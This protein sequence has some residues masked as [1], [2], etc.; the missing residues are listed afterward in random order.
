MVLVLVQIRNG[1]ITEE[2]LHI[3]SHV[4][5]QVNTLAIMIIQSLLYCQLRTRTLYSDNILLVLNGTVVNSVNT[6]LALNWHYDY[7]SLQ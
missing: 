2:R 1:I 3:L 7:N 5:G 4:P 6:L